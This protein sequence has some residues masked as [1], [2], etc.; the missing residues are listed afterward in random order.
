MREQVGSALVGKKRGVCVQRKERWRKKVE[1]DLMSL[2][3]TRTGWHIRQGPFSSSNLRCSD[4]Q[5]S[6]EGWNRRHSHNVLGQCF[7]I[8]TGKYL[9]TLRMRFTQVLWLGLL[10][11]TGRMEPMFSIN[12]FKTWPTKKLLKN[13][14]NKLEQFVQQHHIWHYNVICA[15]VAIF[16]LF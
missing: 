9:R 13:S 14:L 10:G 1:L 7:H 5:V 2:E 15:N 3:K 4:Q 12:D 11:L 8:K 6:W 16:W